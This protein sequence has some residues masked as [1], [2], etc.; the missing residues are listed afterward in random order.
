MR[1]LSRDNHYDSNDKIVRKCLSCQKPFKSS[2][3]FNRLCNN[4]KETNRATRFT[5]SSY[6]VTVGGGHINE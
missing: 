6:C 5:E 4:C 3:K 1:F 2:H